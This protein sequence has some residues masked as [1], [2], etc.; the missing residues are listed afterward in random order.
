MA[1][2]DD[3]PNEILIDIFKRF[4]TVEQCKLRTVCQRWNDCLQAKTLKFVVRMDFEKL[5]NCSPSKDSLGTVMADCKHLYVWS[6][7]KAVVI[8]KKV[9]I[10]IMSTAPH[11]ERITAKNVAVPYTGLVH[12]TQCPVT[13]TDVHFRQVSA[14]G[15]P[16]IHFPVWID[17]GFLEFAPTML[18]KERYDLVWNLIHEKFPEVCLF[19]ATLVVAQWSLRGFPSDNFRRWSKLLLE[20]QTGVKI[21]TVQELAAVGIAELKPATLFELLLYMEDII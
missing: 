11:L 8:P 7:K 20:K 5:L 6:S 21:T 10:S 13:F 3:I 1:T 9:W 19:H 14:T 17:K 16:D 15:H 2:F 4:D 18:A 12:A